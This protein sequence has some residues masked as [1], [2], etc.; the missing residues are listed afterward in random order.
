MAPNHSLEREDPQCP[1]DHGAPA[2]STPILSGLKAVLDH[3]RERDT[4]PALTEADRLDGKTC[5]VTGPSAGLG[6]A[7]APELA[8]RGCRV[9]LACRAGH[10]GLAEAVGRESGNQD[11]SQRPLDLADLASVTALCDG[12]GARRGAA[13]PPRQQRRHRAARQPAHPRRPA[14]ALPGQLPGQLPPREPA[15]RRRRDPLP[16]LRGSGRAAGRR[17]GAPRAAHRHHLLRDAP[18]LPAHRLRPVRAVPGLRPH[19]GNDLVR[20]EQAVRADLRLRAG[21]AAHPGGRHARR[22]GLLVLPGRRPDQHLPRGGIHGE[23]H[24]RLLHRSEGGDVAGHPLRRQPDAGGPEPP[25]PLPSP[26]RR[27]RRPVIRSAQRRAALAAR[28]RGARR[29]RHPATI[30]ASSPSR[31]AEGA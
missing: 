12:L 24:D 11:V 30:V 15:P 20:P 18:E 17:P 4:L 29:A 8:R 14:R 2:G 5:L 10:E 6:R 22:V 26:R 3:Y 16:D 19:G 21:P 7:I 25:L 23:A 9:I 27:D 13:R 1:P 28:P 31:N